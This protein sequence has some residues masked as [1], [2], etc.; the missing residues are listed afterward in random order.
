M[1]SLDKFQ[2]NIMN[3]GEEIKSIESFVD[4]VRKTVG[5]YLGY[6]DTRGH[7]NMI[8]E[9]LQNSL[10]EM[11]KEAS[12]CHEIWVQFNEMDLST[13]IMDTGRGI[14]FDNIIRI[15]CKQH[16][17]SNYIKKPG[18]YSSGRHGVGSKV[19]NACSKIFIIES[20]NGIIK[21]GR[22]V[23]FIEGHP[24]KKGEVKF[25]NKEGKQGTTVYFIPSDKVMKNLNTTCED[26]L[27]LVSTLFYLTP[28]GVGNTIH[29]SGMKKNGKTIETTMVNQDGILSF[30]VANTDSP[31]IAPIVLS[32]DNGTIKADIAFTYDNKA[33]GE[34]E[35]I[36]S[37]ANMCPTVNSQSEHVEGFVTSLSNY[38]R[39]YMNKIYLTK[40]K[41]KCINKDI[42]SGLK[43]VVTVS[44][45]EPIFSG[46]AKEIFSGEG[47]KEFIDELIKTQLDQWIKMNA[48]DVQRLCK[49]YKTVADLRMAQDVDK[50]N[51]IKKV[52]S[53]SS[54]TGL[55][56]KYKPPAGRKDL[57][58][59]IAEGDSAIG[60]V[61]GARDPRKQG[62]FPL[63]GKC[64]NVFTNSREKVMQN[65]EFC[66]LRAI[67]GG[68]G[69]GKNFDVTKCKFEKVIICG[70]ADPDGKNIRQ[71]VVKMLL[72]Y[73]PGLIES[74]RV[75][76][77]QPPLYSIE[78]K[79]GKK[80]FFIEKADYIQYIQR[81]FS[82]SYT[83]LND[84]KKPIQPKDLTAILYNN[85]N[86]VKTLR[87]IATNYALDP[88]LLEYI[89]RYRNVK[90]KD[91][92][93]FLKSKYRFLGVTQVN[94]VMQIDGLIN[95]EVNTSVCGDQLFYAC[96]P[97]FRY[98]DKS[99]EFFYINGSKCTLYEL[100]C[101]F[102][103]FK[104][105]SI[106]RYKG[107]GEMPP[108][109][110]KVSTIHPD[111][112]RILLQVTANNIK[113]NIT[114]IREIQSDL[115]VLLKDQ[116]MSAFEF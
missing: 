102:D 45:L 110:L 76:L 85:S 59:I 61:E 5:Q 100:M 19:T 26:V 67:L 107:L 58:L 49:Y 60:S 12:P 20:F 47:V 65:E 115:S 4:A 104:P 88:Q 48:Q 99:Y 114:K 75:Y 23:E 68:G 103:K 31:V 90:F 112:D 91:V 13:T 111:Y 86:Y 92:Q 22:R 69:I 101:L 109:D 6:N 37:F 94:G 10:D 25:K 27:K 51:F 16:T 96:Q 57:E 21:E 87:T 50:A 82:S 7:I 84:K 74:G 62:I 56:S 28:P 55:P 93:K 53:V 64:I 33:L 71:L 54:L 52:K 32:A 36:I 29:F 14:P 70:D 98:I 38:F 3:Y 11:I 2:Q 18:E 30:I 41:T 113:E 106:Q 17:S 15:F 43:A 40:G 63:R 97:L 73:F 39:N 24:W 35:D 108:I 105:K 34:E 89:I 8:R 95:E 83:V 44:H 77:A 81:S 72:M 46:Q 1:A 78:I 79:K 116:D 80:K 42:M 9:I 66:A